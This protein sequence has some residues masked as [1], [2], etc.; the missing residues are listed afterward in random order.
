MLKAVRKRIMQLL[1][2]KFMNQGAFLFIHK[3]Q[4][5]LLIKHHSTTLSILKYNYQ[6]NKTTEI[7]AIIPKASIFPFQLLVILS[8][9]RTSLNIIIL[10]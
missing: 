8:C 5:V 6:A 4:Y 2:K 3:G 10:Q 1:F 9:E 7:N